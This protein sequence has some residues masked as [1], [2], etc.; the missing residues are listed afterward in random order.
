[1]KAV[2][3]DI[4]KRAGCFQFCAGQE[5]GYKAAI[6]AIPYIWIQRNRGNTTSSHRKCF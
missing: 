1:M 2:E 6:L 5:T 4:K 3:E